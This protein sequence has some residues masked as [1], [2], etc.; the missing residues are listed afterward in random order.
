MKILKKIFV[1]MLSVSV[2]VSLISQPVMA[3]KKKD[4]LKRKYRKGT[5][6]VAIGDSFSSGEGLGEYG[7]GLNYFGHRSDLSWP[8]RLKL[9]GAQGTMQ[10]NRNSKFVLAANAGATTENVRTTGN[11]LADAETGRRVGEQTKTVKNT[12]LTKQDINLPGQLDVF[13]KGPIAAEEVDY[14][15]MTIGGNDVHFEDII[16]AAAIGS[17]GNYGLTFDAVNKQ[18]DKLNEPGGTMDQLRNTYRRVAKS[19]PNATIIVVGYPP[20][21]DPTGKNSDVFNELEATAINNGVATFNMEISKLVRECQKEG[22]NIEFVDVQ[23]AFKGHEAYSD[24]PWINELEFTRDDD[25]NQ[26]TPISSASIHPNNAGA[27]AIAKCVQEVIDKKEEEKAKK[28]K[29]LGLDEDEPEEVEESV[30]ETTEGTDYNGD[31]I[32]YGY[33]TAEEIAG[34]YADGFFSVTDY[35]IPPEVMEKIN[36]QAKFYGKLIGCDDDQLDGCEV[37]ED[38]ISVSDA[39]YPFILEKSGRNTFTFNCPKLGKTTA[40]Y[41]SLTGTL[42]VDPIETN[43]KGAKAVISFNLH[44][45]YTD[46]TRSGVIISGTASFDFKGDYKGMYFD[47]NF[48]GSKDL[49]YREDVTESEEWGDGFDADWGDGEQDWDPDLWDQWENGEDGSSDDWSGFDDDG[50]S[51][52]GDQD[53]DP[54]LWNEWENGEV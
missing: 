16:G 49:P 35:D 12:N 10:D 43:D 15:T 32:D 53:W 38:D 31:V 9:P 51:G 2:L 45:Y 50:D 44:C 21:I 29:E 39:E 11:G 41:D 26:L 42:S 40:T 13:Q 37:D 4:E 22:I 14:V 23:D 20:L 52:G 7:T 47:G 8:G 30:T 34:T 33:P 36:K 3:D 28:R 27:A 46:E 5:N 24:K 17:E 25:L 18:I 48:A 19:A 1:V 54:E 6:L